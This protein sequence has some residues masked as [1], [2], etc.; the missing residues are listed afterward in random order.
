MQ[1]V[2]LYPTEF[3]K[4]EAKYS[5]YAKELILGSRNKSF[6]VLFQ[7]SVTFLPIMFMFSK[8]NI[9][10]VSKWVSMLLFQTF[11]KANYN[12]HSIMLKISN[13]QYKN[14]KTSESGPSFRNGV[15][16]YGLW[17]ESRIIFLPESWILHQ[18]CLKLFS[19]FD[20]FKVSLVTKKFSK[21]CRVFKSA[22]S[23]LTTHN[24]KEHNHISTGRQL[25]PA[26]QPVKKKRG[27]RRP[28]DN[29]TL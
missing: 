6:V 25:M 29:S 8:N 5:W 27:N 22:V 21:Y 19:F 23:F 9:P 24:E 20:D 26:R 10:S 17:G 3:W 1:F 7:I 15:S 13:M 14:N 12:F 16:I 2:L 4:I 11:Q 28:L 18:L